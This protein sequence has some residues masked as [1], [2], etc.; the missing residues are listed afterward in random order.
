LPNPKTVGVEV[1]APPKPKRTKPWGRRVPKEVLDDALA[2]IS[3]GMMPTVA[4]RELGFSYN[5]LKRRC[6]SDP[7]FAERYA[8]ANE[9]ATQLLEQVARERAVKHSDLL[10]IFLLKARR[11]DIY[12]DNIKHSH[13]GQID[14]RLQVAADEF[15]RRFADR[16]E[17]VRAIESAGLRDR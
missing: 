16:A 2:L 8:E 3:A 14:L 12:R 6:D 17:R 4:A 15:R 10:M 11:P 9:M 1:E 5:V 13:E 7:A